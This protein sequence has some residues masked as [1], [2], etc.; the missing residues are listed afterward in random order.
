MPARAAV[1]M[2]AVAVAMGAAIW[3]LRQTPSRQVDVTWVYLLNFLAVYGIQIGPILFFGAFATR[4][5]MPHPPHPPCVRFLCLVPAYNEERVIQNSVGSL[6]RQDYPRDLFQVYVVS[7]GSGDRTDEIARELGARVLRTGIDGFGKHRALGFA[8]ER[9][10]T[11]DDDRYVCVFDADNVVAPNFLA[12]MNNAICA[13]G[14]RCL[15]GFHDCLNGPDNWITKGLWITTVAAARLYNWGRSR[16]LGVALIC[17]TAWCCQASLLRKYWPMIRTQTED[18]ELTGLLLLH[19]GVGV[20]W[21]PGT[22]AYD[23]K[24]QNI[25]VAIRQRHRWMTG[26]MRVARHLFWPCLREGIRRRD[27]RL[28]ELAF[29]YLIPFVMN[30]SNVQAFLLLGIFLGVF[31]IHGPLTS[32]VCRWGANIVTVLYLFGFQVVGFGLRTGLWT[33]SALYSLYAAIFS[34]LAWTPALVWACFTVFRKDWIFHTPHTAGIGRAAPS[35]LAVAGAAAPDA[36]VRML[37]HGPAFRPIPGRS[38]R[39]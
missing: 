18:I 14:A 21:V 8:F 2:A 29:Y 16:V 33:R 15:Q 39:R 12:E 19:E 17:G 4:P 38:S 36:A 25:W 7:D 35:T 27:A 10:L 30:L 20:P 6:V 11:P 26:H 24:P 13:T 28:V 37:S 3:Y 32:P 31:T 9:L 23:E 1:I 5:E 34:P 22:C